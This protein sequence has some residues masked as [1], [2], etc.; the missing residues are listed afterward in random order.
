VATAAR[1][2]TVNGTWRLVSYLIVAG[3]LVAV[4]LRFVAALVFIEAFDPF[5]VS[6]YIV[7]ITSGVLVPIWAILLARGVSEPGERPMPDPMPTVPG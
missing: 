1:V 3:L 5:L 2:V 4:A 7:A 6:D